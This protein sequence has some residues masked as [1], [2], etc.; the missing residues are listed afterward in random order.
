MIQLNEVEKI[1][2]DIRYELDRFDRTFSDRAKVVNLSKSLLEPCYVHLWMVMYP[3]EGYEDTIDKNV[4]D[5]SEW[6]HQIVEKC[7]KVKV[8]L[9]GVY[10]PLSDSFLK[11]VKSELMNHHEYPS[12]LGLKGIDASKAMNDIFTEVSHK[13]IVGRKK[14]KSYKITK[15]EIADVVKYVLELN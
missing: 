7:D 14:S 9:L 12:L 15:Q 10:E 3:L 1:L 11:K 2:S 4:S 6:L 8:Q 5:L 13:L